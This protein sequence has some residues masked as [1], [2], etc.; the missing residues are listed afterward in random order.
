MCAYDANNV[1]LWSWHIWVING[2]VT[3]AS[4]HITTALSDRMMDRALGAISK[5]VDINSFG[6]VSTI[7]EVNQWGRCQLS[8]EDSCRI[9]IAVSRHR[10]FYPSD[11]KLG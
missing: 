8:L 3:N 11:L 2:D 9:T 7:H 5:T 6:M 4:T 1:I 10:L